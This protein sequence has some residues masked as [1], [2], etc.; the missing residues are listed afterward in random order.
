MIADKRSLVTNAAIAAAVLAVL[1]IAALA[2]DYFLAR[3][4]APAEEKLVAALQEQVRRDASLAP[5][6]EAD[7][8]RIADALLARKKRI[9]WISVLLIAA[10]AGFLSGSKWL[11]KHRAL[12]PPMPRKPS[13]AAV[14]TRRSTP[15]PCSSATTS[16]DLSFVD[17][18][19]IREG[20]SQEAAIPILQAIQAHYRYLPDEAL[21][22][23]CEITEITPAQIAGTSS[24]YSRFRRSPVG[25][26]IVRV[27]H[28]TACHV[29]GAR[30]IT[31]ELRRNL[32]IPEGADTD[33]GRMFTVEEV[34]CLGCCSLAPV[35]MLDG[36]TVGKLTPASACDAL[37]A[38]PP[39]EAI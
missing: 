23:V 17:Q 24:F 36:R 19:V 3:S 32:G 8:K 5:K 4:R 31:D 14:S 6:L 37:P 2:G 30:Q 28:G 15:L 27:C 20:R 29:S 34:A 1:S 10:A 18:V 16:I 21:A 39:V 22:R 26:H 35:M 9:N 12:P 25:E 38:M 33:P 13:H 11:L 7:K